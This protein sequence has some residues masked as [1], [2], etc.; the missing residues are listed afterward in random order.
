MIER[1]WVAILVTG[2][3]L[4]SLWPSAPPWLAVLG[5]PLGETDNHLWMFWRGLQR[6]SGVQHPLGN[7]PTGVSIPLMDPVNFPIFAMFSPLGTVV[8]YNAMAVVNVVISALGAYAL[9]R[10]FVSMRPAGVALVSGGSA[11]FLLGVI[12]FGITESWPIGWFG[13]HAALMIQFARTGHLPAAVGAGLCLGCIALSGWYH[14]LLGLVMEVG[15]VG[16]LLF[17]SRRLGLLLQ[18]GIGLLM[19]M[20]SLLLFLNVRAQWRPRWLAPAPGPPGP[21]PDWAELPIYGTDLL[22]YVL[23]Q[24]QAVHPSKAVYL[25]LV[26]LGLCGVGLITQPRRS[27]G[28]LGLAALPLLL[29]LGYWPTIAGHAVGIAGPAWWL[30]TAIPDLQGLS[31]WHRASGAAIPFLAAMAAVGAS[32]LPRQRVVIPVVVLAMVLDATLLSQTSWPRSAYTL[33]VPE[34]LSSLP[35]AGGVVQIPFDN[36]RQM[37]SD[38][39]ARIYN[40]WQVVHGR[41]ISENYEGIDAL[42][43][44]SVLVAAGHAACWNRDTLPPYYQPP[45]DMR[46]PDPPSSPE[47]ITAAVEELRGWGFSSVVLHRERCRVPARAIPLLNAMLGE[48]EHMANGDVLWRL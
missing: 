47:E 30:V 48:G 4:M 15:L 17:R 31:H 12:D 40:R 10:Q 11:P 33:T 43:A 37:F 14:A 42:L 23:P 5:D 46:D 35:D 1:R 25:G 44:D 22:N 16:V 45:P 7:A 19:V 29:G 13:L 2:T 27:V 20:P 32:A 26:T 3:V 28:L 8:A 21:R 6:V 38:E 41:P 9:A 39:P 34:S 24:F 36:S 18:G